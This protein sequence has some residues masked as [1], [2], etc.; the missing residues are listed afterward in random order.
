MSA[1]HCSEGVNGQREH[2]PGEVGRTSDVSTSFQDN[3]IGIDRRKGARTWMSPESLHSQVRRI[4]VIV[5]IEWFATVSKK[6]NTP[7][8][9]LSG[10][11]KQR[12]T[13]NMKYLP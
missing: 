10:L 11:G 8:L 5:F 1:F 6:M 2:I 4:E 7:F 3:Y 12:K 13:N 9:R